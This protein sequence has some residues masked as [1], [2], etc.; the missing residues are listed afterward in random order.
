MPISELRLFPVM[1]CHLKWCAY[2]IT[3]TVD[4]DAHLTGECYYV[5]R[6]LQYEPILTCDEFAPPHELF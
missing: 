1:R 2:P 4:I 5:I 6:V 3:N